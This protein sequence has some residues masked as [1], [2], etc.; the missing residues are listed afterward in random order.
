ME[1]I[2]IPLGC[3]EASKKFTDKDLEAV[4]TANEIISERTGYGIREELSKKDGVQL[5][6]GVVVIQRYIVE[7][8]CPWMLMRFF[9]Q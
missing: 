7:K 3:I 2:E 5:N 8:Y 9:F 6:H 4:K 1:K